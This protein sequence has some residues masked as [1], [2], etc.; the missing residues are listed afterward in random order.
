[1]P[2]NPTTPITSAT[3]TKTGKYAGFYFDVDYDN[4]EVYKLSYIVN[5][6]SGAIKSLGGHALS[7]EISQFDVYS[8]TLA[9]NGTISTKTKINITQRAN[10]CIYDLPES[11]WFTG[12][13]LVE[14]KYRKIENKEDA[15][16]YIFV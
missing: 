11:A 12:P 3:Y 4:T 10:G 9:A 8:V 14:S 15:Y 2:D 1:L 5:A 16:P 7:F 6:T 13:Y